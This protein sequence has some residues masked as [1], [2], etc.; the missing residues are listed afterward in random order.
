MMGLRRSRIPIKSDRELDLMREAAR[1]VGEILLEVREHIRPGVTTGE[2]EEIAAKSI[3]KRGV[4]SSFKGY[5][6]HGLPKYPAVLCVSVND[7]IVHG[8]P[9]PRE[10]AD[11]DIVSLDFGVSVD[12]YHGDSAVTI[13]V[14]EIEAETARLLE[15]TRAS[16]DD[17]MEV[18][19]PGAR[20]SDLG[21]AIQQR[22]EGAGFGVVRE[23]S[24][25][26]IGQA[27]HEEPW[28]PNFGKPGRGPRL[29]CGMVLA[30]EPM[31]TAGRPDVRMLDDEWT[32]VTADGSMSAHF[33]HTILVTEHGGEAL[34]R[35]AGSH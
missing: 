33:E 19:R 6:P 13:P 34:T 20:L 17:A 26:G 2:L 8:I 29:E 32:A 15:V 27:L 25:H 30:V 7:E 3:A 28:I 21:N 14:G 11:G 4:R 9:G 35:I 16:L 5:D 1:H 24:G 12:G 22:A 10:L 18:M 31:V 23:F